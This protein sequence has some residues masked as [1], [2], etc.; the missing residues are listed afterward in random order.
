MFTKQIFL[1]HTPLF[2]LSLIGGKNTNSQSQM[3]IIQGHCELCARLLSIFQAVEFWIEIRC[4]FFHNVL[5]KVIL[6]H[7]CVGQSF[8]CGICLRIQ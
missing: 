8:I 1:L 5:C 6:M 3:E 2:R 4:V 7:T